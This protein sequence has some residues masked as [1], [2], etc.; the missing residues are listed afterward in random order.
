MNETMQI[1]EIAYIDDSI[2]NEWK[3]LR[4][5]IVIEKREGK[6]WL[7]LAVM[8]VVCVFYPLMQIMRERGDL[9]TFR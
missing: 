7:L 1:I 5:S 3:H 4:G 9:R 8:I 6:Y 2:P